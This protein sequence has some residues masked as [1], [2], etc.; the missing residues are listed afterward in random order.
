MDYKIL[1]IFVEGPDDVRFFNGIVKKEFEKKLNVTIKIHQYSKKTKKY[2][3]KFIKSINSMKSDY[4]F[5]EDYNNAHCFT[6]KKDKIIQ[7]FKNVDR[8]KILIVKKEIESWY[9]AGLNDTFCKMNKL[10]SFKNTDNITKEQFNR[11]IPKRYNNSDIDFM[12]EIIS[13]FN[14]RLAKQKNKS[15]QYFFEKY[16]LK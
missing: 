6:E 15:F 5:A 7:I 4:I 13:S 1:Y 9:L 12:I 16:K 8:N 3:S 10:K 11:R 14:I 2:I